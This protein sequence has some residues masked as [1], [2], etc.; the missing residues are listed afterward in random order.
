MTDSST[1]LYVLDVG[2]ILLDPSC[3]MAARADGGEYRI[4]VSAFL[5]T[6]PAGNVLFDTGMDPLTITEPEVIWGPVMDQ[7]T[8]EMEEGNHILKQLEVIGFSPDDIRYV[9]LSH[10]HSDHAGA[11]RFFPRAE[12]I[13]QRIELETAMPDP[14]RLFYPEPYRGARMDG[15]L[16]DPVRSVRLIDGDLDL[17][18]DG[19]IRMLSTPGHVP[20]HQSLLVHLDQTGDVLLTVDACNDRGQLDNTVIPDG[21]WKAEVSRSSLALLRSLRE[22]AALTIYGHD[23]EQWPNIRHSPTFYE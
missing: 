21:T 23:P 15:T 7:I 19:R 14:V 9:I 18:G 4:P 20:G 5:I 17:F 8:P 1:R 11:I 2:S 13:L 16:A 10:L 12:F 22:T 3:T 6:H